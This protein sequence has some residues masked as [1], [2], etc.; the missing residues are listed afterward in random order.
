[1]VFWGVVRFVFVLIDGL[2]R[3]VFVLFMMFRWMMDLVVVLMR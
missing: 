2:E 1:M 3:I